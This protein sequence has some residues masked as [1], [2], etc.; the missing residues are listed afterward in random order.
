MMI[1]GLSFCVYYEAYS[2]YECDRIDGE[3]IAIVLDDSALGGKS[4]GVCSSS[5]ADK[6]HEAVASGDD[7]SRPSMGSRNLRLA[8]S[9]S[10]SPNV[11]GSNGGERALARKSRATSCFFNTLLPLL[12]GAQRAFKFD[13]VLAQAS[14]R[15]CQ[16]AA[17]EAET[18]SNNHGGF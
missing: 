11:I 5:P 3:G 7:V 2:T 8:P 12:A 17:G 4:F 10:S 14:H 15:G 6:G 9:A 16:Q 13:G 18:K 1:G